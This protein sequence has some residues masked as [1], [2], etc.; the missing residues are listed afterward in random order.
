MQM[1]RLRGTA[2]HC[3]K[4]R[5]GRLQAGWV[6]LA[7]LCNV[8]WRGKGPASPYWWAVGVGCQQ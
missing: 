5:P 8:L 7:L 6:V 3:C 2:G 4:H 1:R